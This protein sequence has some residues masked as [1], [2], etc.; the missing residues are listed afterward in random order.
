MEKEL[1]SYQ[2]NFW[3][4]VPAADCEGTDLEATTIHESSDGQAAYDIVGR[5]V[6]NLKTATAGIYIIGNEK[7]S[8][9]VLKP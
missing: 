9:K 5:P 7:H 6:A 3:N 4:W 8:I 1:G 2:T